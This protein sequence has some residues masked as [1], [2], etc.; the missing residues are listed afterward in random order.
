MLHDCPENQAVY[1]MILLSSGTLKESSHRGEEVLRAGH[2]VLGVCSAVD[3]RRRKEGV[4]MERGYQEKGDSRL[5]S[6][7]L[8]GDGEG[9]TLVMVWNSDWS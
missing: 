4:A 1:R 2:P 5:D 6:C 9:S 7:Q 8:G 3:G